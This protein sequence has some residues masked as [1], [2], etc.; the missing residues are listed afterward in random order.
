MMRKLTV[1]ISVVTVQ[2][3]RSLPKLSLNP[4]QMSTMTNYAAITKSRAVRTIVKYR[5]KGYYT[6]IIC[7][8]WLQTYTRMFN[9]FFT[10]K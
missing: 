6:S 4:L 1:L 7:L 3:V 10:N 8:L 5:L 9:H 2:V